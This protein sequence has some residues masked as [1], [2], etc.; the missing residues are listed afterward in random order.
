MRHPYLLMLI[1]AALLAG[2][3]SNNVEKNF[4]KAV[5]QVKRAQVADP[6][7]LNGNQDQVVEG[8]DP[9]AAHVALDSLRKDTPPRAEVK[10]DI[11][12]N[13][14]TQNGGR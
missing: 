12:I 14:G 1:P 2:C 9:E 3:A 11:L 8:L 7:T 5:D 10:R 4:G 13:V 6:G